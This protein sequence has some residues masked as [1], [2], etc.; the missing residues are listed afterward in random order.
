[1]LSRLLELISYVGYVAQYMES[2]FNM[3]IP[4]IYPVI[5]HKRVENTTVENN[6]SLYCILLC[7]FLYVTLTQ[8]SQLSFLFSAPHCLELFFNTSLLL[9]TYFLL[10]CTTPP[11]LTYPTT[12]HGPTLP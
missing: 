6:N 12:S 7:F 3:Y 9:F 5:L 10:Y 8:S 2:I 11:S 4:Y 1:M